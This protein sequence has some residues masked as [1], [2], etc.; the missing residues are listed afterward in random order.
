M[1]DSFVAKPQNVQG[2]VQFQS[3]PML[4]YY[5]INVNTCPAKLTLGYICGSIVNK[6]K[7][8]YFLLEFIPIKGSKSVQ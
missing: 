2:A 7:R 5:D 1:F 8:F 6:A 4:S 3:I